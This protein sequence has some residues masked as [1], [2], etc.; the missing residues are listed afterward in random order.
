MPTVNFSS[1]II[2]FHGGT[3]VSKW[4]AGQ[5]MQ[6][7]YRVMDNTTGAY[8]D[9]EGPVQT[10]PDADAPS[11]VITTAAQGPGT[12]KV[13]LACTVT[14]NAPGNVTLSAFMSDQ[15]YA[16]PAAAAGAVGFPLTAPGIDNKCPTTGLIFQPDVTTTQL[17]NATFDSSHEFKNLDHYW[18]GSQWVAV[19]DR[20]AASGLTAYALAVDASG[21]L[22]LATANVSISDVSVTSTASSVTLTPG[23]KTIAVGGLDLI[24]DPSGIHEVELGYAPASISAAFPSSAVTT[25]AA[26]SLAAG[27]TFA[28]LQLGTAYDVFVRLTDNATPS[29]NTGGWVDVGSA[30]PADTTPP[31]ASINAPAVTVQRSTASPAN[32][33]HGFAW[34]WSGVADDSQDTVA[35][36]LYLV[37]GGSA[38]TGTAGLTPVATVSDAALTTALS[39]DASTHASYAAGSQFTLCLFARDPSGNEAGPLGSVAFTGADLQPPASAA[40]SGSSDTFTP[41]VSD[42]ASFTATATH[43]VTWSWIAGATDA[44]TYKVY[45]IPAGST[46]TAP[47]STPVATAS[48]S[49][50][51][52]SLD[53]TTS[54]SYGPNSTVQ[55]AV[56]AFDSAGNSVLVTST[57]V[58]GNDTM[59]PTATVQPGSGSFAPAHRAVDGTVTA[60]THD[61]S[62]AWSSGDPTAEARVYVFPGTSAGAPSAAVNSQNP[63]TSTSSPVTADL[64][65][66]QYTAGQQYVAAVFAFDNAGNY[67]G[68]YAP[69]SY[70]GHDVVP[71]AVVTAPADDTSYED[72]VAVR[73]NVRA[74]DAGSVTYRAAAYETDQ[75]QETLALAAGTASTPAG[76]VVLSGVSGAVMTDQALTIAGLNT[77]SAS[78]KTYHVYV[79]ATDAAGNTTLFGRVT[80]ET[81]DTSGGTLTV[82]SVTVQ[83][84]GDA[85]ITVTYS[86]NQSTG[87][88]IQ[89][90]SYYVVP[91]GSNP[92]TAQDV[93][94][95]GTSVTPLPASG[96][97]FL[98]SLTDNSTSDVYVVGIDSNGQY[99]TLGSALNV[100]ADATPPQITSIAH[101]VTSSKI[102]ITQLTID[103][104]T[105]KVYLL[106]V[107]DNA[108]APSVSDLTG[109]SLVW[110]NGSDPA[111]TTGSPLAISTH[112]TNA[113][114]LAE[115]GAYDVYALTEDTVGNQGSVQKKIDATLL[116]AVPT[117]ADASGS[118]TVSQGLKSGGVFTAGADGGYDVRADLGGMTFT[119]PKVSQVEVIVRRSDGTVVLSTTA[120]V[121]LTGPVDVGSLIPGDY[122]GQ[123]LT[124]AVKLVSTGGTSAEVQTAALTV[125]DK[126]NPSFTSVT[127]SNI[128]GAVRIHAP[129]SKTS[130]LFFQELQHDHGNK[131]ANLPAA[132]TAATVIGANVSTTGDT[133]DVSFTAS[134][135]NQD[136]TRYFA[137]VA[138]DSAGNTSAVEVRGIYVPDNTPPGQPTATVSGLAATGMVVTAGS[139]TDNVGVQTVRVG[140]FSSGTTVQSN[141]SVAF[142]QVSA[143]Q[144][145][146]VSSPSWS[147]TFTGL[148]DH[149]AFKV[150]AIAAD[151][152]GNTAVSAAVPVTTLDGT[153][154]SVSLSFV[155]RTTSSITAYAH[156][157]DNAGVTVRR[158]AAFAAGAA[159]PT[160]ET[161]FQNAAHQVTPVGDG[162]VTLSGLSDNTEFHLY[163]YA[164]DARGNFT[165]SSKL[166]AT[167]LKVYAVPTLAVKSLVRNVHDDTM[168]M[169]VDYNTDGAGGTLYY[170]LSASSAP[171]TT[172]SASFKSN[173]SSASRSVSLPASAGWQT[174]TFSL[175]GVPQTDPATDSSTDYAP[176]YVHVMIE[177]TASGHFTD[178]ETSA[179]L[180]GYVVDPLQY[181]GADLVGNASTGYQFYVDKGGDSVSADAEVKVYR[182]KVPNGATV[183]VT[184][185]YDTNAEPQ[186][187][188]PSGSGVETKELKITSVN[189]GAGFHQFD[190]TESATGESLGWREN[191]RDYYLMAVIR[192]SDGT[193]A[194]MGIFSSP[195]VVRPAMDLGGVVTGAPGGYDPN[196]TLQVIGANGIPDF[197]A[198]LFD[199][200]PH[201]AVGPV[202][203]SFWYYQQFSGVSVA[204]HSYS[205]WY[206]KY[207]SGMPTSPYSSYNV[208][209]WGNDWNRP[210][211][212]M[213]VDMGQGVTFKLN[214]ATVGYLNRHQSTNY[215]L[216][217][218][219]AEGWTGSSWV[220]L[221]SEDVS[222]NTANETSYSESVSSSAAT[223]YRY[224]RFGFGVIQNYSTTTLGP[225]ITSFQMDVSKATTGAPSFS[226]VTVTADEVEAYISYS[227]SHTAPVDVYF[228][229][230]SSNETDIKNSPDS[231]AVSASSATSRYLRLDTAMNGM[232]SWPAGD[233]K[234]VTLYYFARD[235]LGNSTGVQSTL[236]TTKARAPPTI[237]GHTASYSGSNKTV[238]IQATYADNVSTLRAYHYIVPAAANAGVSGAGTHSDRIQAILNGNP[239]VFSTGSAASPYQFLNDGY[240]YH[241]GTSQS[242]SFQAVLASAPATG[243]YHVWTYVQDRVAKSLLG[244]AVREEH[245]VWSSAAFTV[246]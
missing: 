67:S 220:Q 229:V 225:L 86:D 234:A 232:A 137:L 3:P 138:K 100:Y 147:A 159:A 36:D 233:S 33:G 117:A 99:T 218:L 89:S 186:V 18:D 177:G 156:A 2:E 77:G 12:Y 129:R 25:L 56:W 182:V 70:T 43:N 59:P 80:S 127:L 97:A 226:S 133:V 83:P 216:K 143:I 184:H 239:L 11:P 122:D 27:H 71:P 44:A 21:N 82:G 149:T 31:T 227:V 196:T 69:F 235:A 95:S 238:T 41:A 101:A 240:T 241:G 135:Q 6:V 197:W 126:T 236:I 193:C 87:S 39:Y 175:N 191:G 14:E 180:A 24:T 22:G 62:W 124:V 142:F 228:S 13:N 131:S 29:R 66:Y 35:L 53:A 179:S 115:G 183:A 64:T 221:A 7:F 207:S 5:K 134:G 37:A 65:Q 219:T 166:T 210:G 209:D 26:G 192:Y 23:T 163:M 105:G 132:P 176:Q 181:G 88:A 144:S 174:V 58:T 201:T 190:V 243:T 215:Q 245:F 34:S 93:V 20:V 155:S 15:A 51:S 48:A 46:P 116:Y 136:I 102:N 231:L 123:T 217:N 98:A 49:S 94:K 199:G 76:A 246:P 72:P 167:T 16:T 140:V 150:Y 79:S 47:G 198:P 57:A 164:A 112:G 145:K 92:P 119:A 1:D 237:A 114:A 111:P 50:G 208:Y 146:Q 161:D 168:E 96:G 165:V 103:D 104:P 120:T 187:V 73:V 203:S 55:Y 139:L 110:T 148:F 194:K 78:T 63:A 42:G 162:N 128:S 200:D 81:K 90:L 125:Q 91:A 160:A 189:Y 118:F 212:R 45:E 213:V 107:T 32:G 154:P 224:F 195:A 74:S 108:P 204:G 152:A 4:V 244:G 30:T 230:L 68:P 214:S 173:A 141:A 106:A 171:S 169:R 130:V 170:E 158:V 206:Y 153:P 222:G 10:I 185:S 38:P 188:L 17:P 211:D 205:G 172:S 121:P 85:N 75:G 40:L 19:D 52:V 61:T 157:N 84:G 178:I 109:S 60:A 202:T 242:P 28:G 223:E 113:A 9:V 8:R 151:A 54:G